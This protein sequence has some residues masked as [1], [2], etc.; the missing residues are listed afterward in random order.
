MTTIEE[1]Q[2]QFETLL[3]VDAQAHVPTGT[4]SMIGWTQT[5]MKSSKAS[6]SMKLELQLEW[7]TQ[8]FS[9]STVVWATI[10]LLHLVRKIEK[11]FL[12]NDSNAST[13]FCIVKECQFNRCPQGRKIQSLQKKKKHKTIMIGLLYINIDQIIRPD[14]NKSFV[15]RHDFDRQTKHHPD[16]LH[17]PG[18]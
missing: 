16:L 18:V 8:H 13:M 15:C 5:T 3:V 14:T 17:S 2:K 11:L 10:R 1:S 7:T 4:C 12:K 6:I 9:T